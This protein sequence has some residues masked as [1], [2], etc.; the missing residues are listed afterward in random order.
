MERSEII[1]T[2]NIHLA[3]RAGAVEKMF[4]AA[5]LPEG[6]D[7]TQRVLNRFIK[8]SGLVFDKDFDKDEPTTGQGV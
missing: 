7:V 8:Y 2:L 3:D 5:L 6:T 1:E 4:C